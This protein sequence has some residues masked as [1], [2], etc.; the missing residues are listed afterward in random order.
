MALKSAQGVCPSQRE[1]RAVIQAALSAPSGHLPL[2]RHFKY[3]F[4]PTSAT[5]VHLVVEASILPSF[6]NRRTCQDL[7][8]RQIEICHK[9][10][11]KKNENAELV[12]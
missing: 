11:T 7:R 12:T 4:D 5:I 9:F 6:A 8:D 10:T 3:E 1:S 2:L